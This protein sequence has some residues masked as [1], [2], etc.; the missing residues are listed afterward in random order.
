MYNWVKWF[1]TY[2]FVFAVA[3]PWIVGLLII[4]QSIIWYPVYSAVLIG[5]A[6]LVCCLCA[7]LTHIWERIG[8][9]RP[10]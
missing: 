6:V 8:D 7:L 2:V 1:Y 10:D 4:A 5:I 3:L 9:E